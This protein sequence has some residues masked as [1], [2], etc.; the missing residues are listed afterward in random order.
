MK[1]AATVLMLLGCGSTPAREPTTPPPTDDS[2]GVAFV[3]L[4]SCERGDPTACGLACERYTEPFRHEAKAAPVCRRG[5]ALG[6]LGA[7]GKLVTLFSEGHAAA[8]DAEHAAAV[9]A[10]ACNAG[11]APGCTEL[12]RFDASA[13][14]RA[15]D[16]ATAAQLFARACDLGDAGACVRLG[17]MHRRGTGVPRDPAAVL[18]RFTRACALTDRAC[19]LRGGLVVATAPQ[20]AARLFGRACDAGDGR[21]CARLARLYATGTVVA[22]DPDR[23]AALDDR[24]CQLWPFCNR[25]SFGS[26]FVDVWDY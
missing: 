26:S 15:P 14:L 8:A 5:C 22:R 23:A 7:C 16:L 11:E 20:E 2:Y 21:A 25:G 13:I 1:L 24:A 12:G 18:A 17:V 6:E 3:T 19:G 9:Y 10:A 4:A